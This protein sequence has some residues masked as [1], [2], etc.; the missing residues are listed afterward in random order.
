MDMVLGAETKRNTVEEGTL[1]ERVKAYIRRNAEQS[2]PIV[3]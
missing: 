2:A 1:V 3:I